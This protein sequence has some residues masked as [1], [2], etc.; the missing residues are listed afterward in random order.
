M[1]QWN[2]YDELYRAVDALER[3]NL[4]ITLTSLGGNQARINHDA[5]D[6]HVWTQ[7]VRF[8]SDSSSSGITHAQSRS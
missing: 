4:R 3:S 6:G 1:E 5:D 8:I 7:T 2:S